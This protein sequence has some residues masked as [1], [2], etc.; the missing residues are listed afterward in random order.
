MAVLDK[1]T[2][3]KEY[4][5]EPFLLRRFSVALAIRIYGSKALSLS[6][7][8]DDDGELPPPDETMSDEEKERLVEKFLRCSMVRPRLASSADKRDPV[9]GKYQPGVYDVED[10]GDFAYQIVDDVR[11]SVVQREGFS[12]PSPDQ[13]GS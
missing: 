6:S 5:G 10:L 3:T 12:E 8:G 13:T 9:T 4:D 2:F 1:T 11:K 7:H